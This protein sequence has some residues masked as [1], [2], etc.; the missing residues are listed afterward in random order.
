MKRIVVLATL[1]LVP[2]FGMAQVPD[3]PSTCPPYVV[4]HG[5]GVATTRVTAELNLAA[6][7]SRIGTKRNDYP[8]EYK[9]AF[10]QSGANQNATDLFNDAIEAFVQWNGGQR[11]GWSSFMRWLRGALSPTSSTPPATDLHATIRAFLEK[12]RMAA[13][14]ATG[15][16][17]KQVNEIYKPAL[18][19]GKRIVVVAHSQGT[20]YANEAYT[21]LAAIPEIGSAPRVR[22]AVAASPASFIAGNAGNTRY[23][24]AAIDW[25]MYPIPGALRANVPFTEADAAAGWKAD[26]LGHGFREIYLNQSLPTASRLMSTINAAFDDLPTNCFFVRVNPAG[27]YLAERGV[28]APTTIALATILATSGSN[29]QVTRRGSFVYSPEGG[30][31]TSLGAGFFGVGIIPPATGSTVGAFESLPYCGPPAWTP[32][33]TPTDVSGDFGVWDTPAIAK[34]PEGASFLKFSTGDCYSGDNRAG[35]DFGARIVVLPPNKL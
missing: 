22:L 5:N 1:T 25:V 35:G 30:L 27:S 32:N 9:L 24:T 29:L 13:A 28:A 14:Q 34:V 19:A 31:S 3:T 17:D 12:A 6:L 7:S 10:A 23:V 8:V 2:F 21:R 16:S 11:S 20:F 26:P 18:L 33:Q 4:V 15:D